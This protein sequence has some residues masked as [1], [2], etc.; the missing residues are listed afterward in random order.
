MGQMAYRMAMRQREAKADTKT[1][2]ATI[3][4]P[5]ISSNTLRWRLPEREQH[6]HTTVV[7]A[8]P[9]RNQ[10]LNS[11]FNCKRRGK[12]FALDSF[13]GLIGD[14]G[15]PWPLQAVPAGVWE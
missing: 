14:I 2:T 9:A 8:L 6:S 3:H 12:E 10:S 5:N 7:G 1:T 13:A 4:N 15:R 11:W